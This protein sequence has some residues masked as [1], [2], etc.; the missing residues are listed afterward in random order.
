MD[1]RVNPF[2]FRFPLCQHVLF[3]HQTVRAMPLLHLT[4][5]AHAD[6]A[7]L[8]LF[9]ILLPHQNMVNLCQRAK[10]TQFYTIF[11]I[12]NTYICKC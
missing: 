6:E 8:S 10:M 11:F 4:S 5:A 7:S 9:L 3:A 1:I 12:R 2:L